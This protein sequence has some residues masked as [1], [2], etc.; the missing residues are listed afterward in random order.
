MAKSMNL[1][2]YHFVY[3]T[4]LDDE[5]V[6]YRKYC[7]ISKSSAL[8]RI[9]FVMK[10]NFQQELLD[11]IEKDSK[12]EYIDANLNTWLK[13]CETNYRWVKQI[14]DMTNSF[15]MAQVVRK[16]MQLFFSAVNNLGSYEKAFE[17]FEKKAKAFRQVVKNANQTFLERLKTHMCSHNI[18]HIVQ[19]FVINDLYHLIDEKL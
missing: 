14:H 17:F 3:T 15:S 19:I 1:H 4:D 10:I 2:N 8:D 6:K 5:L 11:H 16:C 7:K 13:I 12:Y 18:I 9:L